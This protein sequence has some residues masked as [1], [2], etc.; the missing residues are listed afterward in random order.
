MI[1]EFTFIQ[2]LTDRFGDKAP[3]L[4]QG[5]GDDC[6]HLETDRQATQLITTDMLTHGVHFSSRYISWQDIG[7]RSVAVNLSD[8]AASGADPGK[9]MHL[10]LSIAVPHIME[11]EDLISFIEGV[12]QCAQRYG[13][14]VAGG[15]S[16][17]TNGPFCV[18][19]TAVG[20]SAHP[21]AR[22]GAMPGHL[23]CVCGSLGMAGAGFELLD[24]GRQADDRQKLIA[25]FARPVPKLDAG[26]ALASH[27]IP[28]AM[29]D[30][31]DG[32]IADSRHLAAAAGCDLEIRVEKLPV[33]PMAI[34][35]MGE[36]KAVELAA[37]FGD[38]YAL[39][40]A[41]PPENLERALTL[42]RQCE[43][44]LVEVGRFSLGS[45]K[46]KALLNGSPFAGLK[47]GYQHNLG[48]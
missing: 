5:I 47:T 38:D 15:D 39:L 40:C 34:S 2:M 18:S 6:A 21:I 45:G 25:A 43:D 4:L 29:M 30:V 14:T 7:W 9:P 33:T 44:T 11:N 46:V 13:A 12:A 42:A 10:F 3:G 35:A 26:H 32:V 8:L 19:I 41:V 17:S 16:T 22:A 31:S 1:R 48:R 23:L 36:E 27:Q 28:S 37:T 20:Y 24:T